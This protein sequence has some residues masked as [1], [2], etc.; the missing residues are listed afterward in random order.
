MRLSRPHVV[1]LVAAA[2]ITGFLA[3][4]GFRPGGLRE[5]ALGTTDAVGTTGDSDLLAVE[6]ATVPDLPDVVLVAADAPVRKGAWAVVADATAAGGHRLT[7]PDASAS[8]LN[9]PLASPVHYFEM[10][11]TAEAGTPYRLWLRGLAEHD[12]LGN[13]SAYVQFS[14]SITSSGTPAFRIGSE[15]ATAFTVEDCNECG[16]AGWGW[17]D[18]GYGAGVMGPEIYFEATG[19]HTIRVQTR[20]DGLSIDQIVLSP[21]TY[22]DEAPGATKNDRTILIRSQEKGDRR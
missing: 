19:T 8:K 17:Q 2:M 9:T 1:L 22:L 10:T 14:D 20:E 15:T 7:H 12:S 13:D 4:R 5:D 16:V 11:F 3:A 21:S 18:N 6:A